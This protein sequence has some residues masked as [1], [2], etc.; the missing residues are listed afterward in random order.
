MKV[1]CYSHTS[2]QNICGV[3]LLI[4]T[5]CLSLAQSYLVLFNF[6][7]DLFMG[8]CHYEKPPYVDMNYSRA[9]KPGPFYFIWC[10]SVLHMVTFGDQ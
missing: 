6:F 10:H 9:Q 8:S 1:L 2:V 4:T 3:T 5:G 7:K